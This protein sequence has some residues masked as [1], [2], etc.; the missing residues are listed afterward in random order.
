MNTKKK[1]NFKD[2]V[3]DFFLIL[4]VVM[5]LSSGTWFIKEVFFSRFIGVGMYCIILS[6]VGVVLLVTKQGSRLIER[7]ILDWLDEKALNGS[8]KGKVFDCFIGF[9]AV[10][11]FLDRSLVINGSLIKIYNYFYFI[12][13][14]IFLSIMWVTSGELKKNANRIRTFPVASRKVKLIWHLEVLII[15]LLMIVIVLYAYA[16]YEWLFIVSSW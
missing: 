10:M 9:Y 14:I 1:N 3:V 4:G 11:V 2:N 16:A 6:L 5:A 15:F 13:L 7:I 8:K 12:W